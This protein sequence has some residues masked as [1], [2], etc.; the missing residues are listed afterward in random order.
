MEHH[1]AAQVKRALE[2]G[3]GKG[4]VD[5]DQNIGAVPM[6]ERCQRFEIDD[7]Q[8]GVGRRFQVQNTGV[9]A[10]GGADLFRVGRVDKGDVDAEAGEAWLR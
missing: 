4:V 6:D 1:V 8:V 2:A 7:F 3:R 10:Q 5:D 9:G